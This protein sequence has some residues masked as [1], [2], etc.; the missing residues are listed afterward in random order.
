MIPFLNCNFKLNLSELYENLKFF[1]WHKHGHNMPSAYLP[2]PYNSEIKKIFNLPDNHYIVVHNLMPI[3]NLDSKDIPYLTRWHTDKHRKCAIM[4]PISHDTEDHFTEFFL[5]GKIEKA[6]YKQGVP[7][8]FN[9]DILHK[10]S[11]NSDFLNRH[12]ISI[13]ISEY[14][15]DILLK[16]YLDARLINYDNFSNSKFLPTIEPT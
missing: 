16:N 14:G 1:N 6:P 10:V 12:M 2:E 5:N 9:T 7:L 4:I 3:K 13:G 8:L 11:N 15:F